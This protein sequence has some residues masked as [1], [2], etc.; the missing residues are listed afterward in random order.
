MGG[1][2]KCTTA[3]GSHVDNAHDVIVDNGRQR[4]RDV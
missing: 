1:P 2:L 3:C 4:N